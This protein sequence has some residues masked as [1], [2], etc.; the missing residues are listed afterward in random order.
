MR[1]SRS[2]RS[3]NNGGIP[4][5]GLSIFPFGCSEVKSCVVMSKSK[6]QFVCSSVGTFF[7]SLLQS[8]F[9]PSSHLSWFFSRRWIS[10]IFSQSFHTSSQPWWTAFKIS[11]SLGRREKLW[12]S[13]ESWESWG[14]SNLSDILQVSCLLLTK[15]FLI[16]WPQNP[17]PDEF[18]IVQNSGLNFFKALNLWKYQVWLCHSLRWKYF[19]P[20]NFEYEV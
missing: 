19:F 3:K 17:L 8:N 4:W 13:Y 12:D 16:F 20:S 14:F 7:F 6:C 5:Y 9:D 18:Y 10:W 1:N 15:H 2:G 11:T